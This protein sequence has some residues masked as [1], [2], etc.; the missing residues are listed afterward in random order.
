MELE[1]SAII[2]CNH[3]FKMNLDNDK[4][5]SHAPTQ[6]LDRARNRCQVQRLDQNMVIVDWTE[7]W[8]KIRDRC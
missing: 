6:G 4:L 2:S 7:T 3:A 1:V 5:T 8:C